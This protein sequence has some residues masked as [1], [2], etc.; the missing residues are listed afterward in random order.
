[1]TREELLDLGHRN[2]IAYYRE[3]AFWGRSGAVHEEGGV[4]CYAS[5]T[6]FPVMMNGVIRTCGRTSAGEVFERAEGFFGARGRG[7][8]VWA[9]QGADDDIAALAEAGGLTVMMDTPEMIVE[10]RLPDERLPP[11]VEIRRVTSVEDVAAFADLNGEAYSTYGM[12]P[13]VVQHSFDAPERFLAPHVH[14]VIAWIGPDAAAG[15]LTYL[16]H[17]I[18]GVYWVG[19]RD[20]FRKQGLAKS[21][22]LAVTNAGF[23]LGARA[24]TLQASV[25]GEPIYRRMGYE[26][27]YRYR[28]YVRM[29]SE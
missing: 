11:N 15:A 7:F 21:V 26:E 12:P 6:G 3:S 16:S 10:A 28:G 8:T 25:M 14:A 29:R 17:G 13:A 20:R 24:N 9:R 27:V 19:T 2:L 1:M 5:S 23:D 4:L 18:A 22:T